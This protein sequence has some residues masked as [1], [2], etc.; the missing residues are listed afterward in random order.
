M[1]DGTGS[2]L[3]L[4]RGRRL[5]PPAAEGTA[6]PSRVGARAAPSPELS[7]TPAGPAHDPGPVW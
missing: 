2:R 1:S 3:P 4:R 6:A 5:L 7:G